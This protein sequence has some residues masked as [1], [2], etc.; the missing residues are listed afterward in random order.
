MNALLTF[1]DNDLW[2]PFPELGATLEMTFINPVTGQEVFSAGPQ[3]G[4]WLTKWMDQPSYDRYRA[5]QPVPPNYEDYILEYT[6]N[7]KRYPRWPD[8]GADPAAASAQIQAQA[9][10]AW[11][12]LLSDPRGGKH[13]RRHLSHPPRWGL[14]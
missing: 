2:W 10:A 7:G 6:I 13:V 14:G 9:Q 4:Y 12:L 8:G 3:R 1:A 5:V 11:M